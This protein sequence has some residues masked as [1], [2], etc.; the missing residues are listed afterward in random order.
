MGDVSFLF[1]QPGRV[2]METNSLYDGFLVFTENYFPGWRATLDGTPVKIYRTN[3]AFCGVLVP[4][5][6]HRVDFIYDPPFFKLG[7]VVSVVGWLLAM[8]IA[9]GSLFYRRKRGLA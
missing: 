4:R 3:G 6:Q 7:L 8:G 1:Y 9:L 2:S 5:G